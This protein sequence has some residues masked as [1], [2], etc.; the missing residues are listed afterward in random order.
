MAP[1]HSTATDSLLIA[2]GVATAAPAARTA[3]YGLGGAVLA[4]FTH[5]GNLPCFGG[6]GWATCDVRSGSKHFAVPCPAS[7]RHGGL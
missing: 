1:L 3:L 7:E 6:H 4:R 5:P 2:V